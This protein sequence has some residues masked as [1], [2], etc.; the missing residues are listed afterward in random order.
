MD[1]KV[2]VLTNEGY[3][4]GKVSKG[5]QCAYCSKPAKLYVW[6]ERHLAAMISLK[7]NMNKEVNQNE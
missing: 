5:R 3:F 4:D 2:N 7:V 1:L 6:C